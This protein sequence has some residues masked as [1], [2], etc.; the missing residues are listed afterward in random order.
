MIAMFLDNR[1]EFSAK[2]M[3]PGKKTPNSLTLPWEGGGGSGDASNRALR[4]DL[5]TAKK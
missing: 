2:Q 3:L 1:L 4:A 5:G